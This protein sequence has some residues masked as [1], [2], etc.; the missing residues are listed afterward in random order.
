MAGIQFDLTSQSLLILAK[1]NLETIYTVIISPTVS[2]LWFVIET[3]ALYL[4]FVDQ[5]EMAL[6]K[7]NFKLGLK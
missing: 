4:N 5:T 3:C 2:V 6:L 7:Q 1:S